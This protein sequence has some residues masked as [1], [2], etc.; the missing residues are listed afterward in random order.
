VPEG[1]DAARAG[2]GRGF[3]NDSDLWWKRTVLWLAAMNGGGESVELI[4]AGDAPLRSTTGGGKH[5]AA[6][7]PVLGA[8]FI[9]R[10]G[11]SQG[12]IEL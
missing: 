6:E 9:L 7:R 11:A 3:V 5:C 10:G 2:G 4:L 8:L 1:I 12:I